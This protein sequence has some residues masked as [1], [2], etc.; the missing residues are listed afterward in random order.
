M[1]DPPPTVPL[2]LSTQPDR[3]AFVTESRRGDA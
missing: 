2:G 3:R 1:S